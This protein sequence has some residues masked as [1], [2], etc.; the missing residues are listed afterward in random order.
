[1]GGGASCLKGIEGRLLLIFRIW[2]HTR[3]QITCRTQILM[4]EFVTPRSSKKLSIMEIP[5]SLMTS[6]PSSGGT[7]GGTVFTAR[8]EWV[9]GAAVQDCLVGI[10]V[11]ID[12]NFWFG[13][14]REIT[15]R[16]S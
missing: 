15:C 4:S 6:S 16:D 8:V 13:L 9:L 7:R 14:P 2:R 5:V 1:M 3:L 10:V 11:L 12:R